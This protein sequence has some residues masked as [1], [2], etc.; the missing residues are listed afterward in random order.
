MKERVK[1]FYTVDNGI[2]TDLASADP[3]R[4]SKLFPY[5]TEELNLLF[6]TACGDRFISPLVKVSLSENGELSETAR[7]RIAKTILTKYGDSW[8]RV[9]TTLEAEYNALD[10]YNVTEETEK[11]DSGETSNTGTKTDKYN[12]F[13]YNSETAVESDVNET[14]SGNTGTTESHS[15]THYTRKGN[16]GNTDFATLVSNELQM[17][18]KTTFMTLI[19]TDLTRELTL[20]IY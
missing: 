8:E 19:V 1:D 17:R 4:F 14:D 20:A 3:D 5:G 12:T 7:T 2:F 13:G 6:L 18:T 15:T 9:K 11:S 16:I 10:P